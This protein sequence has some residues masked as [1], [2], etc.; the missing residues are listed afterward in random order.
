MLRTMIK[1]YDQQAKVKTTPRKLVYDGSEEE[2]LDSFEARRKLERLINKS[3][4]TFWTKIRTRSSRKI[5]R[6]L[7]KNRASSHLRRSERLGSQSKYKAKLRGERAKSEGK[8]PEQRVVSSNTKDPKSMDSFEELSQNSHNKK[9]MLRILQ[10]STSRGHKRT[11]GR[12]GQ[13][14]LRRNIGTCAPYLRRDTFTPLTKTPK[15]ILAMEGVNFPPPLPLI[16]T[17]EKHNLNKFCDYH[18]DKGHNTN[19][20]FHLKKQI[21][22]GN[23]TH[24]VKDIHRGNQRNGSHGRGGMKLINM[25]RSEGNHK[26]PYEMEGPKLTEEIAFSAI[27]QSILTDAPII[28]EGTIE[29]YHVLRIYVDDGSSSEIMYEYYFKSFDTDVKSRLKKGNDPLVGFSGETYHAF[30]LIDLRVTMRELGKSKTV[31]LEFAIIKCRSPENVIMER[32][33]MRS[34]RAVGSTIHSM[35]KFPTAK[36]V[37]IMKTSKEAL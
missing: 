19:D 24:L 12:G 31:L 27:L 11:N 4:G 18:G 16:G 30:G 21:A 3:S 28:F 23:L 32:T 9:A 37:A 10:R 1:E 14:E 33:E 35:I 8:I 13:R 20:C 17:L 34:L 2:N 22:L 36:G 15:E 6:S 26:R 7:S 25:I 5:Q 29:G